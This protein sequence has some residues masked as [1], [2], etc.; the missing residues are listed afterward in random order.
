M[1]ETIKINNIFTHKEENE[2]MIVIISK[3]DN[4]NVYVRLISIGGIR[5]SS[6][7]ESHCTDLDTFKSFFIFNQKLT[8]EYI[9]ENIIK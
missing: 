4:N 6:K 1:Y 3:I 5:L 2:R 9:I 7:A 8:D